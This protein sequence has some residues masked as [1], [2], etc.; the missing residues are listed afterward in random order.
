MLKWLGKAW[1][2]VREVY[3]FLKPLR[4]ILVPLVL[5]LWALLAA[6]QGQ[7][8]V[9]FLVEVDAR[10]PRFWR[11]AVFLLVTFAA[12]LQVWYWSR[13]LLRIQRVA[14]TAKSYPRGEK[15]VPRLLGS[16]VFLIAIGALARAA[17]LGWSGHVDSTVRV[18]LGTCAILLLLLAVFLAFVAIRR[19]KL[20]AY[21]RVE[22]HEQLDPMTLVVLRG[23]AVLGLL[24]VV[25]TAVSPVTVGR[26][27]ESPVLLMLSALLWAGVGSFLGYVFDSH[28]V[29][30]FS[31]FLLLL[32]VFSG[33]NDNHAVRTLDGGLPVQ[34]QTVDKKFDDWYGR[35]AAKYPAEGTHPVFIVA[36]EGGGVRAAYWTASV[37]TAIQ[38]QA[39]QFSDHLFAISSV[40]GGSLGAT[41]FTAL[42][43]DGARTGVQDDCRGT[44]NNRSYRLAARQMLSYD[45]LAPTLA[46]M[47]HADFVQRFLPIGFIPDR[48]KALETGWENAWRTRLTTANGPDEFFSGGLLKMYADRA[49]V[50]LPSLFLNSTSVERGNR[51][52]ASN[53]DLRDG[54][55]PDAADL[56]A[57]LGRDLRLSTAAHNS[58]RFTYVSPAGSVH[59]PKGE[60]NG[61]LLEHVV[62]GGYFENSGAATAADIIA[63]L[64][65]NQNSRPFTIHLIL[66]KFAERLSDASQKCETHPM[67]APGPTRFLNETLSPLRALLATRGARGVLA[68]TEALRLPVV[69]HQFILTQASKG[70]ILPL[71]WLLSGR[72]RNAIDLQI[73]PTLLPGL[74]CALVPFVEKNRDELLSIS[75]MLNPAQLKIVPQ[76]LD[77]VQQEAST[78]EMK[79]KQ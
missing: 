78:S 64:Q 2:A 54:Q 47:L 26:W 11:I 55:I 49:D 43:A 38:D 59:E 8:S 71:G 27:F 30:L 60:R 76:G 57:T 33:F 40:S 65:K 42:V 52:I 39:P 17:Y 53:C 74:D 22:T 58:A 66:I 51:V 25:L 15:W 19:R 20:G 32:V 62:D 3:F 37:L 50:L 16:S 9:R 45:F 28:R 21:T 48:A 29:P 61:K 7:D 79:A 23:T 5:L 34:R 75:Q 72:T 24:F 56:F 4:F 67:P 46:S 41:V 77:T 14:A 69:P 68:Y 35:L 31:T 36:T 70:I 18:I 44:M 63:I 10:C 1:S 6:A 73:G 12:A 13:Q